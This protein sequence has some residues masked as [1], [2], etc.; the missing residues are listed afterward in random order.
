MAVR[1]LLV[2]GEAL[3]QNDTLILLDISHNPFSSNMFLWGFIGTN[4]RLRTVVVRHSLSDEQR[5][6]VKIINAYRFY[7]SAPPLQVN[8]MAFIN[9]LT[10]EAAHSVYFTPQ[11]YTN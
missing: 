8:D 6:T 3:Q 10:S 2:L 1:E 7:Q 5:R 11:D 4:S 9:S